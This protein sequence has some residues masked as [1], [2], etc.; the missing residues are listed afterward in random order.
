MAIF[1]VLVT[2]LNNGL[3]AQTDNGLFEEESILEIT[4]GG[5]LRDLL[6][7]R[8]DNP[9]LHPISLSYKKGDSSILSLQI[10]S[11]TRGHFR[12]QKG[13]CDYPPLLLHF[14]QNE[15][16]Q[17]SIFKFQ[18]N[19]KLV[20]P[21]DGDGY[22]V[23]EYMA[24]KINNLVT[25][26]SFRARL[27][28]VTMNDPNKKKTNQFYGILLE[29]ES[30]VAIRNN[31]VPVV[32]KINPEQTS[33]KEFLDM[34]VFEYLIGN[35]DWSIQYLQNIKLLASDSLAVPF[36]VA[37]DFDHAG[38]VSAPYALP[39]EELQLSSVRTRLYRGYCITDMKQFDSTIAKFNRIRES[40][41]ALYSSSP[42]F[43][44]KYIKSTIS[45]L[46]DF[47]STIN[48]P[49]MV[50]REFGYPCDKNGTG[51]IIIHGLKNDQ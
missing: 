4:L 2:G 10:E 23:K 46:D 3:K 33:K 27:V 17:S 30:Q 6:N 49:K 29:E 38:I 21:C 22:V 11:K 45:Y 32:R 50:Q 51:N 48:N 13:V 20:M 1:V 41:Y 19:L 40:I 16:V 47:Y 7:D 36:T 43:D 28:R 15:Q 37:Y 39:A 12:K 26:K 35:T 34:A 8:T 5:N 24:Y 9:K 18:K 31:L 25:P 42:L 14:N 44:P